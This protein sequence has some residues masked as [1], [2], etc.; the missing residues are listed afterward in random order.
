MELWVVLRTP[1]FRTLCSE[2]R[3]RAEIVVGVEVLVIVML[4][5]IMLVAQAVIQGESRCYPGEDYPERKQPNRLRNDKL[6]AMFAGL[7]GGVTAQAGV[8]D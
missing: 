4:H 3:A 2:S 7:K 6:R 5:A 1:P 8:S